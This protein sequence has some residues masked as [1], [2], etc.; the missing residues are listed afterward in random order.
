MSTRSPNGLVERF[1][2]W[3]GTEVSAR[4]GVVVYAVL[5]VYFSFLLLPI[6]YLVLSTLV[7]ESVL[8]SGRVLPALSELTIGHYVTVL[9]K[10][11]FQRYAVNSIVVATGTTTLTLLF[12]SLAG[13][14]LSRFDFP[15]KRVLLLGYVSTQMLPWVLVLIPFFLVM[16]NLHLIDTHTGI[17]LAHT[18]FALPF[19]VWLLK[20]YF[21]DIP[22]SLD[23]AARMD[24]CSQYEVMRHVVFPLALPG[25]AVAGFY[26]FVLSWNDYLAVSIL[27]QTAATRTLPFGLQLFQSSN[28]VNWGLVLTA[29]TLT[30][31]PVVVLFSL[32]QRWVVEG[33]AG[34][35]MKGM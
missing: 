21:D 19:A 24:G 28:T 11:E 35:G 17:V 10:G 27:S 31:L 16:F 8:Y 5:G 1:D 14:A 13:Y 32:V 26:T 4:R 22:E 18:A 30:M 2:A 3:L 23:E 7:A 15:G 6:A 29:A 33:L 34:G 12:G 20:G 25:M 9:T